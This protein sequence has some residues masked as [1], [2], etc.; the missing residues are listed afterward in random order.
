MGH[1]RD[2]EP[3]RALFKTF[4]RKIGDLLATGGSADVFMTTRKVYKRLCD[5]M[6]TFLAASLEELITRD[7][8]GQAHEDLGAEAEHFQGNCE[9]RRC[10]KT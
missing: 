6:W 3:K 8:P 5:F 9:E 4:K 1:K 7:P 2:H 10:W